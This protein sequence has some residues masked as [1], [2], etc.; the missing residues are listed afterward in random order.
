[1]D[2]ELTSFTFSPENEPNRDLNQ[3]NSLDGGAE[4]EMGKQPR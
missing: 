4:W 2:D 1:M 3:E